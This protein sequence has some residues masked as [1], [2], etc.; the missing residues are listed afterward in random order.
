M[1]RHDYARGDYAMLPV[2][3]PDGESTAVQMIGFAAVLIPLSV[4]PTLVGSMGWVYGA[5]VVPLGGWFLWTTIVFYGERTGQ[6]AKRVL[7]ASVLYIPVLVALMM[8]DW[9]V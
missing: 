3:E 8:V 9:F 7:K 6:K 4:L 2:V 1:Y 5:A